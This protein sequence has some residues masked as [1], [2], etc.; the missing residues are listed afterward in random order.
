MIGDRMYRSKA[1]L[2]NDE[3]AMIKSIQQIVKKVKEF[4]MEVFII[5]MK[6]FL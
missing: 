3:K 6:F 5:K 1:S 4:L 2:F